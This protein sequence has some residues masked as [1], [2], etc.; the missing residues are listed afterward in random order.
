[1][2]TLF[3]V[4]FWSRPILKFVQATNASS[5]CPSEAMKHDAQQIHVTGN[6][7]FS[8]A[9][10]RLAIVMKKLRPCVGPTSSF[11]THERACMKINELAL[12]FHVID[13]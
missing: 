3:V 12:Y 2:R 6:Q 10:R 5:N 4:S 13:F 8:A 1:M 9:Q 11:E 7:L